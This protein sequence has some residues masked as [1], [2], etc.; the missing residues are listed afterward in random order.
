MH[1]VKNEGEK[2]FIYHHRIDFINN[3]IDADLFKAFAFFT[4]KK[5]YYR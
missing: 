2:V 4:S 3:I 1:N 5:K